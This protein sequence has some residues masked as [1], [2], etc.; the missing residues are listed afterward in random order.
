MTDEPVP[1][2]PASE[3][4]EVRLARLEARILASVATSQARILDASNRRLNDALLQVE[5][6]VW[7]ESTLGLTVPLPPTRGWAASPD[8]LVELVRLI[9]MRQPR[10]V[11]EVGS[12]VSTIVMA[13]ALR[14]FG[15]GSLT[16]I[17]HDGGF[18][19][20]TRSYIEA[21]NLSGIAEVI[22]APLGSVELDSTAW[23]WYQVPLQ[24]IPKSIDLLFIDGP[25]AATG[26]LARYPAMPILG[27]A[28]TAEAT[29]V[30]DD[31][32]REDERDIAARWLAEDETLSGRE[33]DTEKGA[34]IF[35][36]GGT[37]DS[38]MRPA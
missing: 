24:A 22:V 20:L 8:I 28:L 19:K 11:C 34:W 29:V 18:A 9:A 14:R 3:A 35:T 13:A 26:R 36:K 16:A 17:E 27:P 2:G 23:P 4:L 33:V 25:P 15:S 1:T 32:H 6:L 37:D 30:M 38:S 21:E 12:G 5:S 7:L 31:T 10:V